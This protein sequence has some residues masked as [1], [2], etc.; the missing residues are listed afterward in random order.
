MGFTA[1]KLRHLI[2]DPL[3]APRIVLFYLL[4]GLFF[5][6]K[7]SADTNAPP[8]KLSVSGYGFF[9]DRQLKNLLEVLQKPG[10]KPPFFEA[11]YIEDAI[12]VLFSRLNRDGYLHPVVR[13]ITETAGGAK[14]TF[15][16]T[17]PLGEPLPRPFEARRVEFHIEPGVLFYFKK[18]H[19]AGIDAMKLREAAHFFIETDA[20]LFRKRSRVYSPEKVQRGAKNLEEGLQRLGYETATVTT[21]NLVVNTNTGA[22]LLDVFVQQGPR[23]IVRSIRK[24]I[25]YSDTNRPPAV[26]IIRTN[27]VFSRLWQEDLS[28]Q[29]K[30]EQYKLG[31]A[32]VRVEMTQVG[33]EA[34]AGTNE[35]DLA[36]RIFPGA[37]IKVGQ[38]VFTGEE[39]AR[40]SM[41]RRRVKVE[42]DDLLNPIKAEQGRYKLARLGIFDSVE[43]RY[44]YVDSETRDV[45][46]RLKEGKTLNFSLL[47]GYGSYEKLRGGVEVE[48]YDLWGLGHYQRLKAVQSFKS[49]S[50][51][52]S[53]TMP[54]LLGED[55][56][57]FLNAAGL[58]RDEIDFTRR[59]FG[60]GAGVN[61]HFR[62]IATD[63]TA[64]YNYQVLTATRPDFDPAYGLK[65]A[66]VGSFVFDLRHDREDNPL[67]PKRGYKVISNLEI[68]SDALL[69]NANFQRMDTSFAYHHPVS[70]FQWIHFGFS[71]GFITAPGPSAEQ[72][73]FNK[74]FFPGGDNSIRGYQL[75]GAAPRDAAGQLVG[76]ETYM[77]ANF[78][79]E[80]GLTRT[81]SVVGFF[82]ALGQAARIEDYPFRE[83]LYSVGIGLRWKTIIGPVRL[84]YGHNLNPRP[85]DP[86]GT[87]HL[88]IGFPF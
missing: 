35:I 30:R 68:A 78:E 13:A 56:D 64:R 48:Q 1:G 41:M 40:E 77:L 38:V 85:E 81:W 29:F 28:Q 66:T 60:G 24:E 9:G 46:Y 82:D 55:L 10:A 37:I 36:A 19:F 23:S 49:S 58:I 86:S 3:G 50:A 71:H 17:A 51:D 11:N 39:K 47:A 87:L 5:V 6:P 12:L 18:I 21:T 52:Y 59:E 72:I 79:F 8:A 32:Y 84:E 70:D 15:T 65:E 44:D 2:F 61:R 69:G 31:H 42:P 74:R 53:Y 63:V 88:A 83:K 67:T 76:A 73:P 25:V 7:A 54:E 62:S 4:A 75:G 43:L 34:H 20:L 57:V 45:E 14:Q 16:W 22:V 27:A 26:Q 33:R 80:Q